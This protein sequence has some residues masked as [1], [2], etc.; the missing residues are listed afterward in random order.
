[1]QVRSVNICF[2][3]MVPAVATIMSVASPAAYAEDLLWAGQMS[4]ME[5]V[6]VDDLAVDGS[7]NIYATGKFEGTVDF[8]PGAGV[9]ELTSAAGDDAFIAKL[10]SG[11]N[12]VW[13]RRVGGVTSDGARG[14]ELHGDG[15]YAAGT[16]S[17]TVD[18]DP[19]PGVYEMTSAGY[20][21]AFVLKLD[22]AGDFVWAKQLSGWSY[23][24]ALAVDSDGDL[25]TV[26]YFVGT[27]DFDPGPGVF[28]LTAAGTEGDIY[29]WKLGSTGD[30][31]WA[32]QL[33]G[34][35]AFSE[36]PHDVRVASNGDV[37][38]A[39]RFQM[40]PVDFDPGPGVFNL[41]PLGRDGFVV[42]LDSDGNLIWAERFG[43]AG[44]SVVAY[45]MAL[46]GSDDVYLT[47]YC[48]GGM[49]DFDPGPGVFELGV[50]DRSDRVHFVGY[51]GDTVD[52]DPGPG[53]FDLT[54][55]G[56]RDGFLLT[57]DSAGGFVRALHLGRG[58]DNVYPDC[59]TLGTSDNI[60]VGGGFKGTVDFDP[61]DGTLSLT[62]AGETDAF[63]WE[64]GV[65]EPEPCDPAPLSQG[66][67]H[68]QCLG[69]GLIS[70]GRHGRGPQGALEPGFV[71]EVVPAVDARL[72]ATVYVSRTC[73]DGI[74]AFPAGDKCEQALRAYT[75]LLLNIASGHLQESCEIDLS[76]QGCSAGN[77]GD[78][79]DE[80]AGLINSGHRN[81][82]RKANDCANTVNNDEGLLAVIPLAP[83]LSE[84]DPVGR[85][86]PAQ[87]TIPE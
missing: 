56:F 26:G 75:A 44:S 51:F 80:L 67:W 82:C 65:P 81:D 29:A 76:S 22:E 85:F 17:G 34:P 30:F 72:E 42:R 40:A 39:G 47:G 83:R 25:Y 12:L 21:D 71:D 24:Q 50:V 41:A 8:D 38:F 79:V 62:S 32:A 68:R 1:M 27:A 74:E 16:F 58:E 5:S 28:N 37:L 60:H 3:L 18:F 20:G 13:A 52:F 70:P 2:S 84:V 14:V 73:E 55:A 35:A 87:K 63:V 19:G 31:V 77:V 69:A 48:T 64:Y 54:S 59:I 9:F 86:D 46:D 66:Y 43:A 33:E 6:Y 49:I 11:G 78:L 4:G 61:T 23:G 7:N 45:G 15:V 10:D 57:L 53:E 36:V